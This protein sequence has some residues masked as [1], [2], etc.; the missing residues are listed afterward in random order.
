M[1]IGMGIRIGG[2][3]VVLSEISRAI[4]FL[5]SQGDNAHVWLPGI[6]ALNGIQAGNYLDSAGTTLAAVDGPVG[7]ANDAMGVLG[8][9]F[10]PSTSSVAGWGSGGTS[11]VSSVS[12]SIRITS[13]SVGAVSARIAD[14]SLSG[15]TIGKTYRLSGFVSAQ[16][17]TL[18]TA[19]TPQM[20]ARDGATQLVAL[21][22]PTNAGN[23]ALSGVFVATA[24]ILTIRCRWDSSAA[25]DLTSYF[26][27]SQL[28]VREISG[29]QLTQPTTASKPVLRRGLLNLLTWSSDFSNAAWYSGTV[30]PV[31]NAIGPYGANDGW[32]FTTVAIGHAAQNRPTVLPNTTYTFAFWVKRGTMTDLKWS[33]YD[34]TNSANI[35]G[36]TS[37]Y[38]QT[39]SEWSLLCFTFT[40]SAT[41]TAAAVYP[42]RDSGVTGTAYFH[43]AGLFQGTLTAAQILA[44]GGIPV[45]TTAPAS[46]QNAGSYF[47]QFVDSNDSLNATIPA[48]YES[49]TIIDAA[50]TGAVTVQGVN[51]SG[52]HSVVGAY[53]T[54]VELV[55]NGGFDSGA[56]WNP[57]AGW[58]ISGGV[59]TCTAS[60]ININQTIAV[61]AN[62]TYKVDFDVVVTLGSIRAELGGN[63]AAAS[64]AS[65]SYSAVLTPT[66]GGS[67]ALFIYGG[68]AFSGS[69]DNVSVKEIALNTHGRILLKDAP[70]APQ[71]TLLQNLANKLAGK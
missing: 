71:L 14:Y 44:Q 62:K 11:V 10:A 9:E 40:T 17:G 63:I 29:I 48:G 24:A 21:N 6:S 42:I 52:A 23:A 64:S 46:N 39:T 38:S 20:A 70:T 65:G 50:P 30:S 49:A 28:S 54:G 13:N 43:S 26:D 19:S 37:Y 59:A 27:F 25:V 58:V 4:A 2:N 16:G 67:Q 3:K 8:V 12:E 5:K 34:L 66:A 68:G 60:N 36:P 61:V 33:V 18:A 22:A 41:C 45:T 32:T 56:N 47:W 55:T 15:F 1:F 51:V 69:I 53:T 31:K 7:R 57:G 35:V